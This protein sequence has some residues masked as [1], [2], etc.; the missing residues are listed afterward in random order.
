MMAATQLLPQF[1]LYLHRCDPCCATLCCTSQ[2]CSSSRPL[3][4]RT[5][6]L[7]SITPVALPS[8]K[9]MYWAVRGAL[10]S[11]TL[12][13][14]CQPCSSSRPLCPRTLSPFSITPVALFPAGVCTGWC[15]GPFA[16]LLCAVPLGHAA[17][18]AR[19]AQGSDVRF[20]RRAHVPVRY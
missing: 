5:L 10:R 17:L 18:H 2:P 3:R 12:C 19:L 9:C 4:F 15:A 1:Y 6:P 14:T 16:L 11:A 8:C 7:C 20:V 13:C